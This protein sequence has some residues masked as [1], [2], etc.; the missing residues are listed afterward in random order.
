MEFVGC[1][2]FVPQVNAW[3]A[4]RVARYGAQS[5]FL[6]AGDTPKALYAAWREAA[7]PTLRKLALHQ[8]DEVVEGAVAGLFSRFFKSEL[9]GFSVKA[10]EKYIGADLAILGLGTNGHVAFHEPGVPPDF[11]FGELSL[12]KESAERLG[13]REGV[14][15]RTYGI[16]AFMEC[17]ALLLLVSGK[18]K[19][20]ALEGMLAGNPK[21]PASGLLP[22]KDLTVLSEI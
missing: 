10:P 7:P 1:K 15:V 16:G 19:K 18:G 22:H 4:D 14:K 2:G 21:I 6:P 8:L 5:L 20:T 13:V 11:R 3:L 12:S 9:P 17:K